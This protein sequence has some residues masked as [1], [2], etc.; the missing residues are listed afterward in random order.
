MVSLRL[1]VGIFS[2]QAVEWEFTIILYHTGLEL[3]RALAAV[4]NRN[5]MPSDM[6]S[7]IMNYLGVQVCS[8]LDS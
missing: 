5:S 8:L 6:Q 2:F 1:K 4:Y 3:V 7:Y